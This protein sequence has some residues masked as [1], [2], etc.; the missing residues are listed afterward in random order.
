MLS[1]AQSWLNPIDIG[2]NYSNGILTDIKFKNQTGYATGY[3]QFNPSSGQI[4]KTVDNGKN[5]IS[6][7]SIIGKRLRRLDFIDENTGWIVGENDAI[8][9]TTDGGNN[10]IDQSMTGNIGT[11]YAISAVDNQK[12]FIGGDSGLFKTIDGGNTWT[13][14]NKQIPARIQFVNLNTGFYLNNAN[15]MYKTSDGGTTWFKIYSSSI[16]VRFSH[17]FNFYNDSIGWMY[18]YK[19]GDIS[20]GAISKTTNGG[21]TWTDQS[22][23]ANGYLNYGYTPSKDTVV[24]IGDL[25]VIMQT[26]NGGNTWTRIQGAS[27]LGF[28][29]PTYLASVHGTSSKNVWIVGDRSYMRQSTDAGASWQNKVIGARETMLSA[30][31][32]KTDRNKACV[33]GLS[34]FKFFLSNDAGKNWTMAATQP[35]GRIFS[36]AY[37]NPNS[38]LVSSDS[39]IYLS[40]DQGNSWVKKFTM[41]PVNEIYNLHFFDATTGW[42]A[43]NKGLILKTTDGGN[44]WTNQNSGTTKYLNSVFFTSTSN[45]FIVGDSNIVLKTTNGGSTWT[46]NPTPTNLYFNDVYFTSSSNGWIIGSDGKV[47]KTTDGGSNWSTVNIGTNEFLHGIRFKNSTE[48][49][50]YGNNGTLYNSTDGG[51]TWTKVA[52]PNINDIYCMNFNSD[53]IGVLSGTYGQIKVFRCATVAP[54]GPSTQNFNQG[55]KLSNL[56]VTGTNIKWYANANKTSLLPSSTLLVDNT[57][58]YVTQTVNN[59]ESDV[60]A[61]LVKKSTVG[62]SNNLAL[63]NSYFYNNQTKELIV[64]LKNQ[65]ESNIKILDINGRAVYSNK[66]SSETRINLSNLNQGIYFVLIEEEVYKLNIY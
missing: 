13:K 22:N 16:S 10:W 49:W 15:E 56:S 25:G 31:F 27:S 2:G 28:S 46:M 6:L 19:N 39:G 37:L 64:K 54:T 40:S 61:I 65:L 38:I 55:D 12:V 62:I 24:L 34:T 20:I 42:A 35:P 30:Q 45:G 4:L 8:I 5:W 33:T 29:D 53:G 50:I 9:K 11:M 32:C 18:G 58:Y 63:S 47:F 60:L 23:N 3:N 43:G 51:N 57:T 44:S 41:T 66:I 1:N 52:N 48:A 59:C 26:T 17:G 14:I 7:A 21:I 36:S